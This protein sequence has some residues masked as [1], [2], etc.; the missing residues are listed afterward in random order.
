MAF[1][2]KN[3]GTVPSASTLWEDFKVVLRGQAQALTGVARKETGLHC[4]AMEREVKELKGLTL[5][6]G[7]PEDWDQLKLRQQELRALV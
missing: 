7:D 4:A 1:F 6:S 5:A 2:K 3:R